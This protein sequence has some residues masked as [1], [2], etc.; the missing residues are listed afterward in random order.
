MPTFTAMRE[1]LL[2]GS[3]ARGWACG[4]RIG[5]LA[6]R[7][8]RGGAERPPPASVRADLDPVAI[9]IQQVGGVIGRADLRPLRRRT[10]VQAAG[11]D[12]RLPRRA[13]RN[14]PARRDTDVAEARR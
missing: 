8:G 1:S 7:A 5:A 11:F 14:H 6:P 4:H 2:E 10:V 13:D 9:R 12:P 3:W